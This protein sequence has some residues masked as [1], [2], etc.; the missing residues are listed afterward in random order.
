MLFALVLLIS[1]PVFAEDLSWVTHAMEA[2]K[3]HEN[4][5][6][7]IVKNMSANANKHKRCRATQMILNNAQKSMTRK[8]EKRYP[9]LLVFVSF[10]MPMEALKALNTQVMEHGGKLVFRGLVDGSFHKM[11]EK[12]KQL[13]AEALIDPTLFGE[14]N[15]TK[16]PVFVKGKDKLIGNVSLEYVLS[17]FKG[18]K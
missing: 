17:K 8:A 2:S 10:S 6:K 12:L 11:A 5:A 3:S 4:S 13:S 16:V 7:Q 9:D 1:T 14:Y 15:I 18:E